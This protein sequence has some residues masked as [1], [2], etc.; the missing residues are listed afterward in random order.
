[1]RLMDVNAQARALRARTEARYGPAEA[2]FDRAHARGSSM[3]ARMW[4]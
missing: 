4:C 1:M 2:L 3:S